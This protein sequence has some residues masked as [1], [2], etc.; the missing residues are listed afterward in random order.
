MECLSEARS[1]R[2]N[3]KRFFLFIQKYSHWNVKIYSATHYAQEKREAWRILWNLKLKFTRL[4]FFCC[5][6]LCEDL[7]EKLLVKATSTLTRELFL[8]CFELTLPA[9][10]LPVL[11]YHKTESFYF[12]F[13]I[14]VSQQP[15]RRER[16]RGNLDIFSVEFHRVS[17]MCADLQART[18]FSSAPASTVELRGALAIW[19]F[20]SMENHRQLNEEVEV[21]GVRR[22][23]ISGRS[24][25]EDE[26]KEE[27]KKKCQL[28]NLFSIRTQSWCNA[29][30]AFAR[31]LLA[32]CRFGEHNF[33]TH[34]ISFHSHVTTERGFGVWK[35]GNVI[36]RWDEKS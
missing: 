26:S 36:Q 15:G 11:S 16:E 5:C 20:N 1:A 14:K 24:D 28:I 13:K 4:C 19:K 27:R 12:T 30:K 22:E 35:G 31:P 25:E 33:P 7:D 9:H 10:A 8:G 32:C 2:G 3:G 17:F 34:N 6:W 29:V 23:W 21:V 18:L